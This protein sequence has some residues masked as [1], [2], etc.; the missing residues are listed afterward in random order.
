MSI[1]RPNL[2]GIEALVL[3]G[4]AGRRVGGQDKGLLPWH[5]RPLIEHV[6]E[7]ISPQV[8]SL[9]ISCN[10]NR[11]VYARHA[12]LTPPDLRQDYQG[13]LAGLEAAQAVLHH[14]RVLLVPCDTPRLPQDL[15]ARLL[16][17]LE[18]VPDAQVCYASTG[19]KAHYLCALLR[20]EALTSLTA[21]LDSGERAVHRW[22]AQMGAVAVSFDDQRECFLNINAMETP[23]TGQTTAT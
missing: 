16:S 17:K 15:A 19:D 4:G 13:P 1:D 21:F 8:C 2:H 5:G 20:R 23:A 14:A 11:H 10:R 6:I 22:F 3:A 12:P 18:S 7:R 9:H